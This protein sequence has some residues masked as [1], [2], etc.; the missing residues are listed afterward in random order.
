MG[1]KHAKE[2]QF[3]VTNTGA[4]DMLL[5]TDWLKKHNPNIDWNKNVLNLNCCPP[6]CYK[7]LDPSPTITMATLLPMEEWESQV[8][9]YFDTWSG[10]TD[11]LTIMNVHQEKYLAIVEP[12]LLIA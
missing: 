5:E 7:S 4:H 1:T 11:T 12:G 6:E 10:N 9:D 3:F 2:L 8:D